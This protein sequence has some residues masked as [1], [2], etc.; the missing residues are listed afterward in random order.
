MFEA[1]GCGRPYIGSDVGGVRAIISDPRLGRYGPAKDLEALTALLG[2]AS[3]A[4]WDEDFISE[5]ARRYSWDE[6]ARRTCEEVYSP[7][8]A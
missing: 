6:I 3:R 4:D 7:L 2:E 5:H 8:I 1:L